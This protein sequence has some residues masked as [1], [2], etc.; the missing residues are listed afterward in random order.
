MPT[1]WQNERT[2]ARDLNRWREFMASSSTI[3]NK[4]TNKSERFVR[5]KGSKHR[6]LTCRTARN[7]TTLERDII[8]ESLQDQA[9]Q[10][11]PQGLRGQREDRPFRQLAEFLVCSIA[12]RGIALG[13]LLLFLL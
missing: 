8:P 5:E 2:A 10:S 3:V 12:R 9:L 11:G 7:G 6:E 4:S 13:K 1:F